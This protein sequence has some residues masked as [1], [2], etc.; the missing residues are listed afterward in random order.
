MAAHNNLL[1][2]MAFAMNRNGPEYSPD[3][4]G[5]I[6]HSK[7]FTYQQWTRYNGTPTD[8][9]ART[10]GLVQYRFLDWS[11]G[12]EPWYRLL[13]ID[14]ESDEEVQ[15]FPQE[16]EVTV[17]RQGP[18]PTKRGF[19]FCIYRRYLGTLNPFNHEIEVGE[20]VDSAIKKRYPSEYSEIS[21]LFWYNIEQYKQQ[22]NK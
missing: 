22:N 9:I 3:P 16:E 6:E 12:I 10:K 2:A 15:G 5:I 4:P 8:S 17:P 1:R 7:D 21:N 20:I 11:P 18:R 14:S 19:T 13:D